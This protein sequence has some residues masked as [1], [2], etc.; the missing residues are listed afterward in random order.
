MK[1]FVS[2]GSRCVRSAVTQLRPWGTNQCIDFYSL[3]DCKHKWRD[4]CVTTVSAKPA[5]WSKDCVCDS[6][7]M[8]MTRWLN[9]PDSETLMRLFNADHH[10]RFFHFC[11]FLQFVCLT[12]FILYQIFWSWFYLWL[13]DSSTLRETLCSFWGCSLSISQVWVLPS[14]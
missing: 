10:W 4:V 9:W 3:C 7:L 5:T 2:G 6:D 13:Q 1:P 8:L 11:S 12:G 14:C